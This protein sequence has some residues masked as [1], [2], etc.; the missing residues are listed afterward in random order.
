MKNKKKVLDKPSVAGNALEDCMYNG[1]WYKM[2]FSQCKPTET[3][4]ESTIQ[5]TFALS[6]SCPFFSKKEY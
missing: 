6:V 4:T 5:T 1:F 2:L 3:M